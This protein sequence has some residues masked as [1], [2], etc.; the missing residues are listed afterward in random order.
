MIPLGALID[1]RPLKPI[2]SMFPKFEKCSLP[3]IF[4]GYHLM[5]GERFYGDYLAAPII[6]FKEPPTGGFEFA[7]SLKLRITDKAADYKFL[8]RESKDKNE[9]SLENTEI[10]YTHMFDNKI[11]YTHLERT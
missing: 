2:L 6:D 7:A 9:C 11:V 5:S 8:L 3:G 1:F 4:L 10:N